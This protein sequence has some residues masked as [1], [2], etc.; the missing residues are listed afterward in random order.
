MKIG[1]FGFVNNFLPYYKLEKDG[2]YEILE[3]TPRRLA[4]MFEQREICYAPIPTYE[5]VKKGYEPKRFCIASD[6][7][8]YSV[9]IVSKKKRLDDSPIAITS[10]SMT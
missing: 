9:I 1:K 2:K 10:Q 7:E 8:V 6:G 3:G 5:L 4:E